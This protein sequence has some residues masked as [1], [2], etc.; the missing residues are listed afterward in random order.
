MFLACNQLL[1]LLFG[2]LDD[3][4]KSTDLQREHYPAVQCLTA[5]WNYFAAKSDG[6]IIIEKCHFLQALLPIFGAN[7]QAL[8]AH[9]TL[10]LL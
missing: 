9:I 8:F 3:I 6:G 4:T 10:A 7:V 1:G 2:Y 5:V